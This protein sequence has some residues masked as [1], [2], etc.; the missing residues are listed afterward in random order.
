MSFQFLF[1]G[2]PQSD[3]S[4]VELVLQSEAA[5]TFLPE[6]FQSPVT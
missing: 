2:S 3:R 5:A 6:D 4:V 1:A